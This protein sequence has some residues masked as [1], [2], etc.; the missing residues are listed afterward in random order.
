MVEALRWVVCSLLALGVACG[1]ARKAQQP[2]GSPG[3]AARR[4]VHPELGFELTW[5]GSEWLL[6]ESGERSPEG[7]VT[8]VTLH[9]RATGAQ[10][11]LQVSSAA[12]SP[13]RIA[14]QL[15]GGLRQQRG[16]ST[17]ELVPL[18]LS[19]S[20]VG[21]DFALDEDVR[22]RVALREGRPGHLF[23]L[24]ATWPAGAPEEVLRGVDA[25]F[26]SVRPLP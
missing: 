26:H 1:A 22:G 17:T 5:P 20:A 21:F 19:D 25:L 12:G 16:F 8:P 4:Y 10:V 2:P 13:T 9:H 24:L 11:M 7:S 18:S 6:T 14:E 3:S 15:M 23:M